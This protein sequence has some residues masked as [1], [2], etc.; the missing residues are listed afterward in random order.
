MELYEQLKAARANLWRAQV[1]MKVTPNL[2]VQ[3]L[4]DGVRPIMGFNFNSPGLYID[5]V[6]PETQWHVTQPAEPYLKC[7]MAP[8]LLRRILTRETHW[9]NA[10]VAFDIMFDRRPNTYMPDVHTLM[11]FFHV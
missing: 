5:H 6:T 9:N 1:R 8:G 4:Q 11:S 3:I 7:S 10:E 2:E